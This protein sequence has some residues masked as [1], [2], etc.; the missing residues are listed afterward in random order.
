MEPFELAS[1]RS[2][3]TRH[4]CATSAVSVRGTY[5]GKRRMKRRNTRGEGEWVGVR[6]E[7]QPKPL[8]WLVGLF[9]SL[10]TWAP[11]CKR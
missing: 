3:T 5:E 9:K 2:L 11:T 4:A 1:Q 10:V 6:W 7:M 8:K